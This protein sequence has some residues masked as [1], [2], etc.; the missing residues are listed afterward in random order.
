MNSLVCES[1]IDF[2]LGYHPFQQTDP[3]FVPRCGFA[4]FPMSIWTSFDL[5]TGQLDG[6]GPYHPPGPF[7][8]GEIMASNLAASS[9]VAHSKMPCGT[10]SDIDEK[11]AW[12]ILEDPQ[13]LGILI[14]GLKH[15]GP[16]IFHPTISYFYLSQGVNWCKLI[17]IPSDGK[18][19]CFTGLVTG[20]QLVETGNGEPLAPLQTASKPTILPILPIWSGQEMEVSQ[21]SPVTRLGPSLGM[22]ID[23]LAMSIDLR[24]KA[25]HVWNTG[26]NDGCFKHTDH[27]Q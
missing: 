4:I 10:E 26:P 16:N 20:N 22:S 18:H 1:V 21:V 27:W 7:W 15:I 11:I 6:Y 8:G 19:H 25:H 2:L 5:T 9:L 17:R 12:N 14:L 13:P 24:G 3:N 23:L